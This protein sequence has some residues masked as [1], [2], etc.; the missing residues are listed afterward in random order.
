MMGKAYTI[1]VGKLQER[2]NSEDLGVDGRLML[3]WMLY[4]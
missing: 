4:M 3:Q 2:E 1:S